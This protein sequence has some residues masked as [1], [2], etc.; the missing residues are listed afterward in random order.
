MPDPETLNPQKAAPL[1]LTTLLLAVGCTQATDGVARHDAKTAARLAMQ[2]CDSDSNGLLDAAELAGCPGLQAAAQR[3][4]ANG[5]GAITADEIEQRLAAYELQSHRVGLV[6][7]VMRN[8]APAADLTVTL[9]LESFQGENVPI[10][11]GASDQ[12]GSVKLKSNGLAARLLP[13]G[14]YRVTIRDRGDGREVVQGCEIADDV[15]GVNRLE[16]EL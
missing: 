13:L 3:V 7:K 9:Q 5:D 15:P 14:M 4:D 11:S 1:V 6:T 8:G 12:T 10:Y 2:Q 16:L